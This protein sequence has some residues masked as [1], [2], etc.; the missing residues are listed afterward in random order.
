MMSLLMATKDKTDQLDTST[1]SSAKL[2]LGKGEKTETMTKK[3]KAIPLRQ[4]GIYETADMFYSWM[5][6][7]S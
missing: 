3:M 5:M 2:L 4:G 6:S 1:T 7:P